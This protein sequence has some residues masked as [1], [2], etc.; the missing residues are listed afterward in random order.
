M[1][2]LPET[3]AARE[4]TEA[5]AI[6]E[7]LLIFGG[8]R[9]DFPRDM[10]AACQVVVEYVSQFPKEE[11]WLL[12]SEVELDPSSYM[13]SEF[14]GGTADLVLHNQASRHAVVVDF[15]YGKSH[16]VLVTH[17]PQLLAYA[18]GVEALVDQEVKTFD[19]VIIQPRIWFGPKIKTWCLT[20]DEIIDEW[21]LIHSRILESHGDK[22]RTPS[23]DA[24]LG[25]RAKFNCEERLKNQKEVIVAAKEPMN[26]TITNMTVAQISELL[27]TRDTMVALYKDLEE[28]SQRRIKAGVDVPGWKLV[29]GSGRR[30]WNLE[31]DE[32]VIKKLMGMKVPKA[33]CQVVK[34]LSPAQAEKLTCLTK[35]QQVNLQK[36]IQAGES[37]PKLVTESTTGEAIV[38]D[39]SQAFA[40]MQT[41]QAAPNE[42][43]PVAPESLFL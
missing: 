25:C 33:D 16:E 43:A 37:K 23:K 41:E 3:D 5:H 18:A 9:G 11:G 40:D 10:Y 22:T 30:S 32:A 24:C 35:K 34:A 17:N 20:R 1:P 12:Y 8:P 21:V 19:L 2:L 6:L 28:E 27:D 36:F 4:G 13:G 39:C 26:P 29:A 7:A 14:D 31:D 42:Q 38:Y 15:K